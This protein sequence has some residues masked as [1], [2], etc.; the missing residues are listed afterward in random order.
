[1]QPLHIS[2]FLKQLIYVT[3]MYLKRQKKLPW[4][5]KILTNQ[6]KWSKSLS[7]FSLCYSTFI[8][9]IYSANHCRK[10]DSNLKHRLLFSVK[11]NPIATKKKIGGVQRWLLKAMILFFFW[12]C[13]S[14]CSKMILCNTTDD[15]HTHLKIYVEKKS[16][17]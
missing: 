14:L 8:Q 9:N 12:R 15:D 7:W 11:K 13:S 10:Q 3:Y 5:H 4:I 2:R 1:M 16:C 17:W 6:F